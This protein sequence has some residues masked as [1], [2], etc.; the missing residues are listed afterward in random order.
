M[1]RT[2]GHERAGAELARWPWRN[3]HRARRVGRGR[4]LGRETA[5]VT[6]ASRPR[7]TGDGSARPGIDGCAWPTLRSGRLAAAVPVQPGRHHLR[8]LAG[9]PAGHHRPSGARLAPAGHALAPPPPEPPP[10]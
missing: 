2:A 7:R 10:P 9:D 8:R 4:R 6:L 5:L 1:D 3:W